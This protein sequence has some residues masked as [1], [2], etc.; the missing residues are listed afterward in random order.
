MNTFKKVTLLPSHLVVCGYV[1]VGMCVGMCAVMCVGMC[2][3]MYVRFIYLFGTA[4]TMHIH[5]C[6][7]FVN[8]M[9]GYIK[10]NK[11]QVELIRFLKN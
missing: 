8:I 2:M 5:T 4:V 9:K 1:C 10:R 7:R 11:I 6:K 3:G